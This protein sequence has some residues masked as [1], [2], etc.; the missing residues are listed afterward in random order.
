MNE[1]VFETT[2]AGNRRGS[3]RL[4]GRVAG[5]AHVREREAQAKDVGKTLYPVV[6]HGRLVR[7]I[8]ADSGAKKL[9]VL[10]DAK[11]SEVA[12]GLLHERAGAALDTIKQA[13]KAASGE[14]EFAF[15]P[16][17]DA[18]LAH[19]GRAKGLGVV[20]NYPEFA[21][22]L[23]GAKVVV[24]C[25]VTLCVE[26][27][28]DV[29]LDDE[30]EGESNLPLSKFWT[31]YILIEHPESAD[32]ERRA[33]NLSDAV[34]HKFRADCERLSN[35]VI[36]EITPLYAAVLEEVTEQKLIL[37][38]AN[39]GRFDVFTLGAAGG[40]VGEFFSAASDG[41][42]FSEQVRSGRIAAKTLAQ[43]AVAAL[44]LKQGDLQAALKQFQ[45]DEDCQ[46]VLYDTGVI[47]RALYLGRIDDDVAR[48]VGLALEA[49][50][51]ADRLPIAEAHH[52]ASNEVSA[53]FVSMYARAF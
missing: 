44:D 26:P 10:L 46:V 38:A 29:P 4:S 9:P 40:D 52:A 53:G 14:R 25:S 21:I 35:A 16:E 13:M 8:S 18:Q 3:T 11:Q 2:V 45:E 17:D 1:R 30:T 31:R 42:S 6:R 28:G 39:N 33:I 27:P 47:E 32:E 37:D 24:R 12:L 7:A 20:Y 5:D 19:G 23:D 48:F 41:E 51:K 22:R 34:L 50:S 15:S 36:D 43:L 49:P